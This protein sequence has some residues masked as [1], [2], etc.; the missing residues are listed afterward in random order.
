MILRMVELETVIQVFIVTGLLVFLVIGVYAWTLGKVIRGFRCGVKNR[1]VLA[2][3]L[4]SPFC[5]A[6]VDVTSCSAFGE[7]E[8]FDCG[9]RCLGQRI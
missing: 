3:F 9:K 6:Y 5:N 1:F 7:G 4:A 2:T 8:P